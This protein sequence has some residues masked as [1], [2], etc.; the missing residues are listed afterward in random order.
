MLSS[1]EKPPS[2]SPRPERQVTG[3]AKGQPA[4]MA[5]MHDDDERL[6]AQIGY[7]Q[8]GSFPR[9]VNHEP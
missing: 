9:L 6:L 4:A 3:T 5:T 1:D 7:E 8:V 2:V